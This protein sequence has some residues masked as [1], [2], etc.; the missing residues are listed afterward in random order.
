[1][2]DLAEPP[3]IIPVYSSPVQTFACEA[4]ID[5]YRQAACSAESLAEYTASELRRQLA[6]G[7]VGMM[8]ICSTVEPGTGVQV[9]CGKIR[10][11]PP[12]FRF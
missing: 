5:P 8:K 7:L 9:V 12:D 11:V 6:D 2:P 4:R 10:V 3:L 1:M